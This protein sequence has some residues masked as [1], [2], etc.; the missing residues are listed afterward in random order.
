MLLNGKTLIYGIIGNPV[1][2]S[3]SPII[4]NMCFKITGI[5]G[6]YLP[7]E[8]NNLED[9]IKGIKALGIKGLSITL[10]FKTDVIKYL[11][12][13]DSIAK[14]IGAVN[15]ILNHEGSLVGYNTDWLGAVEALKEVTELEGKKTLILGAGGAARAIAYGLKK[16]GCNVIITNRSIERAKKLAEDMDCIY[17]NEPSSDEDIIINATNIG[18]YPL[19][20]KSPISRDKLK[21]GM[22]VMDI[23]YRPLKTRFLK[24]AEEVGCTTID[25]LSMLLYQGVKQ[26]QIWT[27]LMPDVSMI[28]RELNKILENSL[29]EEN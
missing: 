1:K 8:I 21:R 7:F 22:I 12:E 18:M 29:Y 9:A 28:K 14:D 10:P 17:L 11:D 5:N 3:L 15:T 19:D 23:V 20:N 6:I 13:I 16:S 27:G 25:G 26:F 24:E 2:H 4:H